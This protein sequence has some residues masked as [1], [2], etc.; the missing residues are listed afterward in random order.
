MYLS[1]LVAS[2]YHAKFS[3]KQF[4]SVFISN[5]LYMYKETPE[6]ILS[7]NFGLFR[8]NFVN[9]FIFS[10]IKQQ[11]WWKKYVRLVLKTC[12]RTFELKNFSRHEMFH[13]MSGCR[14]SLVM[15][16]PKPDS[17]MQLFWT[18]VGVLV[19]PKCFLYVPGS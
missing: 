1:I 5:M 2:E 12:E 10:E 15:S 8:E 16:T 17:L 3:G 13:V 18:F 19:W 6:P 7:V 4:C 9:S 11:R 14:K